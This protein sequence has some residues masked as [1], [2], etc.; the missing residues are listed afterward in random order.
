MLPYRSVVP[1]PTLILLTAAIFAAILFVGCSALL[2]VD[3]AYMA[4]TDNTSQIEGERNTY[5]TL[6]DF[7]LGDAG[8]I[9]SVEDTGLPMGESDTVILTDG[10]FRSYVHASNRSIGVLDSCGDPVAFPGCVVIYES[11]DR[12]RTFTADRNAE[13][14]I[15]C[16]IPCQSCP[17]DSKRDHIDQQQ[18]PR[19]AYA[20]VGDRPNETVWIMVYEYR[21]SVFVRTSPD[22]GVWSDAEQLPSTGIWQTWLIPCRAEESIG[23]HPYTP[24]Q[25]DC[26][27][28]GPPGITITNTNSETEVYIFVGAGQNPGSMSCYRG[29]LGSATSLLRKCANNPLFTGSPDY[30]HEFGATAAAN[31]FFDFR[32]ISSADAVQVGDRYYMVYEGVRGPEPNTPGDTQFGLGLARSVTPFIDGEWETFEGNP[33]L[34]DVPANIGVGHADLI[35]DD[36]ETILFTSLDGETRSRLDLRWK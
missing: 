11:H 15:A 17:C 5:P 30:G 1:A 32:T 36:G 21:G 9:V 22:G 7:W 13:G 33:I 10:T 35:V 29:S 20:K 26:L 14:D 27:V 6:D 18:Y 24:Y 19:I 8:F 4:V 25:Y 3:D 12:G 16:L 34:L 2:V 28:G 23:P 31:K